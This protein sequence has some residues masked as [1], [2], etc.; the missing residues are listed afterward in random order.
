MRLPTYQELSKEQDAVYALPLARSHV[1]SGPP[2]TGKTVVALHRT[3]MLH[4]KHIN[5]RLLMH[6]RLLSQYTLSAIRQLGISGSVDTFHS[7]FCGFFS[8]FYSREAPQIEDYVFDWDEIHFTVATNPPPK[9]RLPHLIIDEGQDIPAGFYPIA[10]MLASNLTVFADEN[11]RITDQNSTLG[12]IRAVIGDGES[13]HQLTKN[14]RNTKEI[15]ELAA[16]FY[17]GLST[18]I[19][20]LPTRSGDTPVISKVSGLKESVQRIARF[21]VSN[22]DKEI[23]VLVQC[24]SQ[25]EKIARM[26]KDEMRALSSGKSDWVQGAVQT[27]EGGHGRKAPVLN[28]DEPG[29]MV[30]AFRSAKGLEWDAVFLPEI[31]SL[32]G[33]PSG[34]ELRM[35]L[36]V[37]L[38][39]ARDQLFLT[40]SGDRKAASVQMFPPERMEWR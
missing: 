8:R 22:R 10:R 33:D 18:G 36:Y 15:A 38:S 7:W 34:P 11:Q 17:T 28:F 24:G 27:Y 2:G 3:E 29:V 13:C 30:L 35:D 20:T 4:K 5:T 1:V 39:R 19:P 6:S 25:R 23:G 32:S 12:V 31:Q 37:M 21:A 9:V 16:H 26:L 40:Y 14:F